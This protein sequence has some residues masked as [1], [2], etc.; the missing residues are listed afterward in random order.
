MTSKFAARL[1]D[2]AYREMHA[3]SISDPVSFWGEQGRRLDWIKP[4]ETVKNVSFAYPDVSIR[5]FE[6]GELNVCANCV[7][8]HAAATPEKTALIF[9]PDG[10]SEPA[11][12]ISYARLKDEVSVFANVLK[13]LG[14]EKGDR[15]VI[16]L[17]MIPAA[18]YAML[19][20]A[21]IGA[22]HS[23]VFA[24]FSPDAVADRVNDC[25]AVVVITA[26]HAP[27]GGRATP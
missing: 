18:A 13:G 23:V 21:R 3:A 16:Y 1:D 2:A 26:D 15:V 6:D 24:G 14:V 20:C 11:Q 25:G 8:R 4:Y 10:P 5:W 27:R 7:D 22:V 19:A 9:E 12:R 17:P